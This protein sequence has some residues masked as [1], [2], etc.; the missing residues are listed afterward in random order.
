MGRR[1][2]RAR[3][4]RRLRLRWNRVGRLALL[5]VLVVL[6]YLYVSAGLSLLSSWN[7]SRQDSARLASL[8]RVN[9]SLQ[10]ER[11]QL[12]RGYSSETQARELGMAYSG[13]KLFIVSGLPRD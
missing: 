1:T 5:G 12:K 10:A 6:V 4:A 11:T 3:S 13:E 2:V 9:A 8:E 7:A